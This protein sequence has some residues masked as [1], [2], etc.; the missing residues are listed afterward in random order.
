MALLMALMKSA[1]LVGA[2]VQSQVLR[3][4][5]LYYSLN[6]MIKNWA[7][8]SKSLTEPTR[9]RIYQMEQY[10]STGQTS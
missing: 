3:T 2:S 6:E 9:C 10:F 8:I 1:P 7:T 4:I 5:E